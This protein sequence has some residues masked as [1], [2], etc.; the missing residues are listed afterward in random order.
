M[1]EVE[2]M[3][4]VGDGEGGERVG[5]GGG[6]GKD[7]VGGAGS[8]ERQQFC[9]QFCQHWPQQF[10]Q[11]F[12]QQLGAFW[13]QFVQKL[14]VRVA[15]QQ[16]RKEKD[17][18]WQQFWAARTAGNAS[19]SAPTLRAGVAREGSGAGQ[20]ATASRQAALRLGR[21]PVRLTAASAAVGTIA[22]RVFFH[23]DADASLIQLL[24]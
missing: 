7:A 8:G 20:R 16:A 19:G 11:Q 6:G 9:Q 21:D 14:Q 1:M 15:V 3:W 17:P 22:A 10:C 2:R 18:F 13:K 4:G 12:C 24:L 5:D 23:S